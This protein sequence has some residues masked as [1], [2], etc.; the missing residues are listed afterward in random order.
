MRMSLSLLVVF[1]ALWFGTPVAAHHSFAAEFDGTKL[2]TLTGAVTKVEWRNPHIWVYLDVRN[3]DGTVTA[4]EVEGGAPNVL[5]RQ[6]W[7]RTSLPLGE[8]VIVEGYLAKDGTHTC[9]ARE[10]R[11]PNGRKLFEGSASDGGSEAPIGR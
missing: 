6:G 11:L 10:W 8:D 7:G 4:W 1:A 5:T 3:A 2:V 9:N